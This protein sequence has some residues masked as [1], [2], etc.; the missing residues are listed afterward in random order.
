[1][2]ASPHDVAYL[3]ALL[4]NA[5]ITEREYRRL[6]A[7]LDSGKYGRKW[8]QYWIRKLEKRESW[9]D[10]EIGLPDFVLDELRGQESLDFGA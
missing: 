7:K 6:S 2:P 3:S 10:A 5:K 4:E 9:S 1:M 8:V